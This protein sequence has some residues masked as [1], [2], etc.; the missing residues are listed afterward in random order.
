M[1]CVAVFIILQ[2]Y[3]YYIVLIFVVHYDF[4]SQKKK[5]TK[6][7]YNLNLHIHIHLMTWASFISTFLKFRHWKSQIF[8][9][10]FEIYML[11]MKT[12][13]VNLEHKF[14]RFALLDVG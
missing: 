7:I 9:F 13:I 11:Y 5:I 14:S 1:G 4:I 8:F 12:Y 10:K 3:A 6:T 2:S